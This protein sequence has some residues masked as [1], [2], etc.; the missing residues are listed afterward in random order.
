[1]DW[2]KVV[3]I[4][5]W[6]AIIHQ[7][8]PFMVMLVGGFLSAKFFYAER[9]EVFRERLVAR[10]EELQ[11]K[12]KFLQDSLKRNL[13]AGPETSWT[14]DERLTDLAYQALQKVRGS[15]RGERHPPLYDE[16][17]NLFM[18]VDFEASERDRIRNLVN[19]AKAN[20]DFS[21]SRKMLDS[22]SKKIDNSLPFTTEELAV[23]ADVLLEHIGTVNNS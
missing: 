3:F 18:A 7:P 14:A 23:I 5:S 20:P 4:D 21:T 17:T 10:D 15:L 16:Q 19:S 2:L 22:I 13:P 1:M 11:R 8:F 6:A 12:D 9:L